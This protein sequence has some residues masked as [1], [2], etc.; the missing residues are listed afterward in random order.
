M[1]EIITG[2]IHGAMGS[3]VGGKI[4]GATGDVPYLD[5]N[6]HELHKDIKTMAASLQHLCHKQEDQTCPPHYEPV[7]LQPGTLIPMHNEDFKRNYNLALCAASVSVNFQ[8]PSL[9]QA[10]ALTLNAGWNVLNMPPGTYWG[11]PSN[12]SGNTTVLYCATNVSYGTAI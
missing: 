9:G 1:K 12:A 2:T 10:F 4:Q 8:V 7:T 3:V 5:R 11:L 6:G